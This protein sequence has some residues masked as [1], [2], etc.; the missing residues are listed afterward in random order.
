MS[1][2]ILTDF[3]KELEQ[4]VTREISVVERAITC[5]CHSVMYSQVNQQITINH[6][7]SKLQKVV[8]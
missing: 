8:I 6:F 2:I 1:F 3:C 4:I 5:H 7:D